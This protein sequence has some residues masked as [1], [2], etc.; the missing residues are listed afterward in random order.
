MF[1]RW[2]IEKTP[3]I[4]V[5]AEAQQPNGTLTIGINCANKPMGFIGKNNQPVGFDIEFA[6]RLA[7]FL[8]KKYQFK[9]VSYLWV[10]LKWLLLFAS[11]VFLLTFA[12]SWE[13]HSSLAKHSAVELLRM[14]L[15]DAKHRV[16]LTH[17]NLGTIVALSNKA[18]LTKARALAQIIAEN[19]EIIHD[20][21]KLDNLLKII[22]VD[23][24]HISDENGILIASIP[25]KSQGYDMKSAEQSKE[26]MPAISN[27]DFALVQAPHP[28][29]ILQILFQYAGVARIDRP[30]IVQIGYYPKRIEEAMKLADVNLIA[31]SIRIG[32]KGALHIFPKNSNL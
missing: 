15:Y 17:H 9:I 8:N 3:K 32:H 30:G 16:E 28:N 14:S 24:L 12:V 31:S 25:H 2:I 20:R 27:P 13:I 18:T 22:D 4:P 5:I 23:E 10:V 6:Q 21:A 7:L 29:G 11:I 19:P 26:F 1:N